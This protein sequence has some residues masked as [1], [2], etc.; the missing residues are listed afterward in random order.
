MATQDLV[1]VPEAKAFLNKVAAAD[2]PK[3]AALITRA[4]NIIETLTQRPLAWRAFTNLRLTGPRS[5]KF[6]PTVWP[7]DVT[8]SITIA[9]DGIAQTIWRTEADGDPD[10]KDVV[11][12]SDDPFD[13]RMGAQNHFFRWA[14]WESALSWGWEAG[15][16]SRD[17]VGPGLPFGQN[18]LLL[19][20]TGGYKPIPEDLKQACCYLVQKLWRDQDRQL[21]GV[22]TMSAPASGAV[23]YVPPADPPVPRETWLLIAPY[24][25]LVAFAGA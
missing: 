2:D 10:Q 22:A 6:Y 19:S 24:R 25:R 12:C 3:V 14:T 18:R 13:T 5:R 15:R 1:T 4:S 7:I 21:A 20:Y 9:L 17:V 8:Q 11:V 23:S 16:Y